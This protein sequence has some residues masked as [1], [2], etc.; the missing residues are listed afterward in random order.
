MVCGQIAGTVDESER[1]NNLCFNDTRRVAL[2]TT[3][4]SPRLYL[5]ATKG[6]FRDW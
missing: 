3:Q 6:N 4:G 1:V 2:D 5:Q